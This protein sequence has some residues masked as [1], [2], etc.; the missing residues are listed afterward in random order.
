MKIHTVKTGDSLWGI[1]KKYLGDGNRF[2]EIQRANGL[3]DTLIT[4]G[5]VLKIPS[6]SVSKYEEIGK[7]FEKAI[8]DV[9][10][11]PSVKKLYDLVGD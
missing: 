1:A 9:D 4:P 5:M 6:E 8:R 10:N 2:K 11:L 7:A 3:K